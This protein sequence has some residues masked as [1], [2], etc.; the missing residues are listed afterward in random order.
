LPFQVATHAT[1]FSAST[2]LPKYRPPDI[3]PRVEPQ[4]ETLGV[5]GNPLYSEQP[6]AILGARHTTPWPNGRRPMSEDVTE[7]LLELHYSFVP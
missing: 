2:P 4:A 3:V 5:L 7:A 6:L 1:K